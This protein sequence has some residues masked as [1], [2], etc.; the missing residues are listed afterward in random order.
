MSQS[1]SYS[2]GSTPVGG[3]LTLTGNAG[4]AVGPTL[5]NINVVGAGVITVTGN[6]GTSTITITS[7]AAAGAGQFDADTGSALPVAGVINIL[8]GTNINTD[9]SGNTVTVNLNDSVTLS[10]SLTAGTSAGFITAVTGDISVNAGNINLPNTLS[11]GLEGVITFGG[12]R[13]INN[14]GGNVFIGNAS[15]NLALTIGSAINNTL[16]GNSSGSALTIGNDNSV[17]GHDALLS[18]TTASV[19]TAIGSSALIGLTVGTG[20]IAIG[21][22]TGANYVTSES[23]NILIGNPGIA[24]EDNTIRI[25][26][27]GSGALEQNRCFI[28]G[29][30]GVTLG[31]TPSVVTID[32]VTG[33]L[34]VTAAVSGASTFNTDSGSATEAGNAITIAG[35]SNINTSGAGSTV[36]I[37]LDNTVSISGSMTAGTGFTATTGNVL[38]SAGNV[39]ITAGNI[40]LPL[41]ATGFTE[42]TINYNSQPFIHNF[43]TACTFVGAN[44]GFTSGILGNPTTQNTAIGASAAYTLVGGDYNAALGNATLVSLINGSNNCAF[45]YAA[46]SNYLGNETNNIC[47]GYGVGGTTGEG[48]AIR[49]GNNSHSTCFITGINGVTLGGTPKYVTIDPVTSQLGVSTGAGAINFIT[50]SGTAVETGGNITIAGSA[51]INTTGAGSAVTVN[52][53]DTVVISGSFTAGIGS[54]FITAAT[55]DISALVGNL[56]LPFSNSS[57]GTIKL[58]G[59]VFLHGVNSENVGLGFGALEEVLT[60]GGP[61]SQSTAI[62]ALALANITASD[63]NTA[64]GARTLLNLLTGFDNIALGM[65][66]GQNYTANENS[67]IVIGNNGTV[68]ENNTIRIGTQGS[69]TAQQNR[70]FIA[71]I[72]GNTVSN[73]QLVTINSSTGQLGVTNASGVT[74]STVT[75]PTNLVA[76]HGYFVNGGSTLNFTLPATAAVGD[77]FYI[78]VLNTAVGGWKINQNAGQYIIGNAAQLPSALVT[79]TGVS[80]NVTTNVGGDWGHAKLICAIANTAFVLQYSEVGQML[81][82]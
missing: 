63:N 18:A 37:N 17:V 58:G 69:G 76:N 55:G 47:I 35:G 73:T 24:S 43:G 15:G 68:S 32:N 78:G 40:D 6:P 52:L 59:F 56:N 14:F 12:N 49:I 64:I 39:D 54:G 19:N 36:T 45:G 9:A 70:C 31:G 81:F 61:S 77:T 60:G 79:T 16:I 48:D 11:T 3:I 44:A 28:A 13:F 46:G 75:G 5:G 4:G 74:W 20:N 42:G 27:D 30:K 51:N 66:A 22:G 33:Q 67:N 65:G 72:T 41:T 62:G 2:G 26:V 57:G 8:G 80:G 10:G 25:G 34:G 1:G 50:D 23:D 38:V 7:S 82:T 29:I 71:G 53:D 21:A